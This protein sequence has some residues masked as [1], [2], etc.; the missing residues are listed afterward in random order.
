MAAKYPVPSSEKILA[1][2]CTN[3]GVGPG[4]TTAMLAFVVRI[5]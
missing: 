1:M 3:V 2:S 5:V 4:G